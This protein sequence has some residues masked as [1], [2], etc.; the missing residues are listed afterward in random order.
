METWAGSCPG[1]R[2]SLGLWLLFAALSLRCAEADITCASCMSPIQLHVEELRLDTRFAESTEEPGMLRQI[3]VEFQDQEDATQFPN[4]AGIKEKSDYMSESP[5]KALRREKRSDFADLSWSGGAD[6][7]ASEDR[8]ALLDGQKQSRS[9]FRWNRDDGKGNT[10]KD[11]PKLSSST[12]A[13]T[14]DSAHN[15]AVVYWS[16]QNSSV[17]ETEADGRL[18]LALCVEREG[19]R[20]GKG[21]TGRMGSCLKR[22]LRGRVTSS[23][24]SCLAPA[25]VMNEV[26]GSSD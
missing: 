5:G 10:R 15:H 25:V 6:F 19:E 12:F 2:F 20:G 22:I 7:S 1:V 16:G 13:L 21:K 18:C 11:E 8:G 14:G 9:D 26:V 4:V 24:L 3:Q 17:M 23:S